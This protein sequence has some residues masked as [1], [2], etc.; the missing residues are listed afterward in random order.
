MRCIDIGCGGG[1]VTL[2]MARLVAPGGAVVGIDMDEVKLGLAR[3]AAAERGL[4]NAEFRVLDVRD[5]DEPGSYDAVYSRFLL[6]HLSQPGSLLRRMWAAVTEGGVLV[7]EDADFDGWCCDPP[8]EGFELFLD[9]YRRVLAQPGRGPGG[10]AEAVPALPG[11]GDRRPAGDPGPAGAPGRSARRWRGPRWKRPPT[12]LSRTAWR[13]PVRSPPRWRAC[14]GSPTIRARSSAARESS[15]SGR[16]G[17]EARFPRGPL[18]V[19][20][21]RVPVRG[22][23][24]PRTGTRA[25]DSAVP[26]D[27]RAP[28]FLIPNESVAEES[29]FGVGG[30]RREIE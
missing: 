23:A 16:G 2:E 29:R 5:W 26:S 6:Q 1:A 27:A 13:P 11:G 25:F 15:S 21:R 18:S 10:W 19:R 8:N 12:P 20:Q 4:S 22:A 30:A 9:A 28:P 7:V 14:A 17:S 24:I 3:Q